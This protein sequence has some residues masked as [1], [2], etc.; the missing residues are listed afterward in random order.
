MADNTTRRAAG[1]SEEQAGL[2]TT[3]GVWRRQQAAECRA[4]ARGK[5]EAS[6]ADLRRRAE[7]LDA[8]ADAILGM[9]DHAAAAFTLGE[10]REVSAASTPDPS[11][12]I[13]TLLKFP[14]MV[15]V[16]ASR[17]RLSMA[18]QAGVLQLALDAAETCGARNSLEKMLAHQIAAAHAAAMTLQTEAMGLVRACARAGY[19]DPGLSVEATRL[20]NASARMMET[21]QRGVATLH[22][23]RTGGLQTVVVQHVHVS[24]G[25]QAV[26]AGEVKARG[27]GKGKS[28]GA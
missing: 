21:A 13:D 3:D 17:Q 11:G 8:E 14:E 16:D 6:A 7:R 5:D 4:L 23:L 12:F 18:R 1:D 27:R 22:R 28:G 19:R 20:M 24:E 9:G 15:A 2:G 26:V 10:G 25:G